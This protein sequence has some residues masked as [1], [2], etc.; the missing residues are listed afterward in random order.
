MCQAS[1]CLPGFPVVILPP[2]STLVACVW[3]AKQRL[4]SKNSIAKLATKNSVWGQRAVSFNIYLKVWPMPP[5]PLL[6]FVVFRM[7][8][9]NAPVA[10]CAGSLVAAC[11]CDDVY[12]LR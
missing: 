1:A 2:G 7:L 8:F 10:I 12:N 6:R 11:R 4:H 5:T 9:P 3:L